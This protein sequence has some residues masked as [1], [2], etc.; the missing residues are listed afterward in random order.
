[1][2][3]SLRHELTLSFAIPL[4][5]IITLLL[6][7]F[8]LSYHS[9]YVFSGGGIPPTV[10][11]QA[12]YK[13]YMK[14]VFTVLYSLSVGSFLANLTN[15][16]SRKFELP[17]PSFSEIKI[18]SKPISIIN[19]SILVFYVFFIFYNFSN[20][21][22]RDSYLFITQGS[23]N[24]AA[25]YLSPVLGLLELFIYI[26]KL[27]ASNLA[28]VNYLLSILIEFS[29]SSRSFGILL[30]ALGFI[31]ALNSSRTLLKV[32]FASLGILGL[33]IGVSLA[34]VFRS[35]TQ[36]GLVNNLKFLTGSQGT[37][38][39]LQ[40]VSTFLVIIPVTILGLSIQTPPSYFFTSFSPLQGTL[41][42]WYK[43]SGQMYV[44]PWT[45]SGGVAQVHNMGLTREIV[46]WI[47]FGFI[48]QKLGLTARKYSF[49]NITA[50]ISSIFVLNASLQILQYSLRAGMRFI[51]AD[52]LL[53]TLAHG[54]EKKITK[55][56]DLQEIEGKSLVTL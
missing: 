16:K 33:T 1:M 50:V 24:G 4:L 52:V 19:F 22:S 48:V 9:G 35:Q 43:I 49:N 41:T 18:S 28:G 46:T 8:F 27:G 54:L 40:W 21:F 7:T 25:R 11:S 36:Q 29:S 6:A 2:V 47:L 44:N 34:L 32:L 14:I 23:I 31:L 51:Y 37:I 39:P 56:R 10:I 15:G 12:D 45:P 17:K 38:N 42:D 26:R 20:L 30:G 53:L 55:S 5:I 13:I 3:T